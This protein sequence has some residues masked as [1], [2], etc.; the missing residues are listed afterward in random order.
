MWRANIMERAMDNL[1]VSPCSNPE[2]TLEQ[3]LAAY[4]RIGYRKF[5]VFTHWAKSA[6]DIHKDPA[7][8]LAL[9]G[10]YGMRDCDHRRRPAHMAIR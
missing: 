10:K 9:G 8:Y 3:A 1:I 7:E 4:C 6:F 2:M 5:E